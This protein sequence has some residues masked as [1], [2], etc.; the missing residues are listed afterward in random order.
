MGLAVLG[1]DH[2]WVFQSGPTVGVSPSWSHRTWYADP[3]RHLAVKRSGKAVI[4]PSRHYVPD[5]R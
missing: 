3:L 1:R 2:A 4:H 5:E